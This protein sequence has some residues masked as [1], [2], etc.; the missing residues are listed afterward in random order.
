MNHARRIDCPDPG[1]HL[2]HLWLAHRPFKRMY[3]PVGVGDADVIQIEQADF[4][5]AAARQRLGRPRTNPADTDHRDMRSRQ[6][7]Q[8]LGAVQTG[9]AAEP[10]IVDRHGIPQ[11]R[12]SRIIGPSPRRPNQAYRC[13]FNQAGSDPLLPCFLI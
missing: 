3:L 9:D 4:S 1:R 7:L 10:L 2:V 11:T 8:P 12:H 13:V 5:N 6:P